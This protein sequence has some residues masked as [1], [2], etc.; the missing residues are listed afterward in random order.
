MS[1]P[2]AAGEV[3]KLDEKTEFTTITKHVHLDATSR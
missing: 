2:M 1:V 3:W